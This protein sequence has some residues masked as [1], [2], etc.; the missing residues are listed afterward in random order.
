M[1]LRKLRLEGHLIDTGVMSRCL[2]LIL[3]G[4]GRYEI[5]RFEVGKT[6]TQFSRAEI[7]IRCP[8]AGRMAPILENCLNL[9]CHLVGE[10]SAR[11]RSASRAGVAPEDFYS[12]T[13][14]A[15]RV[16][17]G[18]RWIPVE[19]PRMDATIVL[20][21]RRAVCVKLRDL[22]KGDRVVCG[23]EGVE[24]LPPFHAREKGDFVFMGDAVSSERAVAVK[25]AEIARLCREIRERGGRIV[26]VAGP[27][28]VHT[29]GAGHL[30]SLLRGGWV[31]ALLAGNALAVHDLEL[32]LFGTSL[33][34]DVATGIPVREGHRH[35]MQAINA[36][37]RAGSIRALVKAKKLKSGIFYECVRRKIPFSLAGSIRDDGP[38]P[39]TQM[40]LLAAQ[41]EYARLL[42]GADLVL[43]LSSM[44]HGIGV[45]NMIPSSVRTVCVDINPAVVTKLADR[46]T[47]QAVGIVTDVG[48]FL[49][50]L[51]RSLR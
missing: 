18:G 17:V 40:D 8:D 31:S 35:H 2:D 47:A 3:E 10:K 4:G 43:I 41:A 37:R 34:V 50:Q 6:K 5:R 7:E 28:V 15:T 44:L 51:A 49:A 30:A 16:L 19:N 36:A 26:V 20:R 33:G 32:A 29:G 22:R 45:G 14:H 39:E 1:I 24:T 48:L 9:G 46:G 23:L 13:H 21:G 25:V 38:I 42:R 12:T 27:V 11:L